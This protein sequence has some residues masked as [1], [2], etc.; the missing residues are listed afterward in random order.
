MTIENKDDAFSGLMKSLNIDVSDYNHTELARLDYKRLAEVKQEVEFQLSSLFDTLKHRCNC[1]MESPLVVD[2]FPRSDVDVMTVRLIRTKIIRLRNDHKC[3]LG[4]LEE[5]LV[6]QLQRAP[7]AESAGNETTR[8]PPSSIIPF[9]LVKSVA[10]SSPA[11]K[12]GLKENDKI[13]LFGGDVHAGN[14]N[15]LSAVGNKVKNS[16]GKEIVVDVLRGQNKET[17][18]LVPTSDWP[19]QGLLGCHIVPY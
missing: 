12:S 4:L 18:I 11:E 6:K 17:L 15:K 1:D 16:V 8:A 19:G 2:G 14:H 5:Q 10:G 3:I 7:G 9:A 13:V